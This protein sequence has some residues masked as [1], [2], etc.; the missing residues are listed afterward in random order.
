VSGPP[1]AV[2]SFDVVLTAPRSSVDTV[3]ASEP[4]P[5]PEIMLG[6]AAEKV[7]RLR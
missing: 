4:E 5:E 6:R 2:A 1:S 3:L 7:T